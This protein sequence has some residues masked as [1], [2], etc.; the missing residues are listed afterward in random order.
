[1]EK[2]RLLIVDDH[3]LFRESLRTHLSNIEDFCVVGEAADGI[4]ALERVRELAPDVV[5]MDFAMPELNGLQATW[6]IKRNFPSTRVLVLTMYDTGPHVDEILRAGA[7]GYVLKRAP[8]E[9]LVCAIR[10]IAQGEA[11]LG[12]SVAK[13]VVNGYLEHTRHASPDGE[14]PLTSRERELLALVAEGKTNRQIADLLCIS[15][16]TVQAHRLNLMKKLGLHDRTQLVRYAIR[17]G[18]ITP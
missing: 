17:S 13:R 18:L 11:F 16:S 10:A 7:S 14:Q 3:T 1:M 12:P 8:T 5:L 9:E 2:I 4:Q 6:Q 15:V